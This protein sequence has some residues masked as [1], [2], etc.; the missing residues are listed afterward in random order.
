MGGNVV[1][2]A[3]VILPGVRVLLPPEPDEANVKAPSVVPAT[4]MVGVAVQVG[5]VADP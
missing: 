3:D 5:F 1:V 2:Y 4:P